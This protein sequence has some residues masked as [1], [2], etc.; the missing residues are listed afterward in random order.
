M[1]YQIQ[2]LPQDQPATDRERWGFA[3]E[4]FLYDNWPYLLALAII[5]FLFFYARYRRRKRREDR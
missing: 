4:D 2:H 1:S 3:F 5:L